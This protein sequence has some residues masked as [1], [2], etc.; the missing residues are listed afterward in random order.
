[1][2][3]DIAL[4]EWD[5]SEPLE[6]TRQKAIDTLRACSFI[7]EPVA[8]V[9]RGQRRTWR[10][11]PVPSGLSDAQAMIA[12]EQLLHRLYGKLAEF[13]NDDTHMKLL[14]PHNS[15][16]HDGWILE[17]GDGW[18]IGVTVESDRGYRSAIKWHCYDPEGNAMIEHGTERD[19]VAT[20]LSAI[21]H[22][23]IKTTWE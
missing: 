13:V 20:L 7:R 3:S 14:G 2:N 6:T 9:D 4:I 11:I 21:T 5:G 23:K 15:S 18:T 22:Y 10:D 16:W 8:I 17:V 12:Q 1:M 19:C